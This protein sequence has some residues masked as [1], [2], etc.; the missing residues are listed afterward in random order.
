MQVTFSQQIHWANSC[1][2]IVEEYCAVSS[3]AFGRTIRQYRQHDEMQVIPHAVQS[4]PKDWKD[5]VKK[6]VIIASHVTLIVPLAMY[7]AKAAIRKMRPM[8]IA[9]PA[10]AHLHNELYLE[11]AREIRL[12][13]EDAHYVPEPCKR[14]RAAPIRFHLPAD[15]VLAELYPDFKDMDIFSRI[16]FF[17][18][19]LDDE[20][21]RKEKQILAQGFNNFKC[22]HGIENLKGGVRNLL[23]VMIEGVLRAP[24]TGGL[25][26]GMPEF[27]AGAHGPYYVICNPTYI[28]VIAKRRGLWEEDAQVAFLVP[29]SADR[30]FLERGLSKAVE[31]GYIT[32]D[33]KIRGLHKVLT[34]DE[35]IQLPQPERHCE[36]KL[37][38]WLRMRSMKA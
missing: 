3:Q 30:T 27:V 28:D 36:Q 22:A 9:P 24:H 25:M 16:Y 14:M 23:N 20:L 7:L 31:L 15:S 33:E 17:S 18:R 38:S 6:I 29:D 5:T 8:I 2:N 35:F 19:N 37:K 32:E 26:T 12:L 34:Y 21:N 11:E 10:L 13:R 1:K 4:L